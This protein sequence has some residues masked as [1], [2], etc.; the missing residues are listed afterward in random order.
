MQCI[1][2][3]VADGADPPHVNPVERVPHLGDRDLV[4]AE[5]AGAVLQA[6]RLT[7]VAAGLQLLPLQAAADIV[8]DGEEPVGGRSDM[9]IGWR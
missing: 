6:E 9:V 4:V 3:E 2:V 1:S 7:V 5:Q 8:Y